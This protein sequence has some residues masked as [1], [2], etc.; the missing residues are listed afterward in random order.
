[1]TNT[2]NIVS[3]AAGG[4]GDTTMDYQP[5]LKLTGMDGAASYEC[6]VDEF[7]FILDEPPAIS[8]A[9]EITTGEYTGRV[10]HIMINDPRLVSEC[11][12]A[13]NI[14][15]IDAPFVTS[16]FALTD[17]TIVVD[18]T[19]ASKSMLYNE[20]VGLRPSVIEDAQ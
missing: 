7:R 20:V 14:R 18:V 4:N 19:G 2:T 9:L 3:R 6:K 16:A 17:R 13:L 8:A 12:S 11:L 5:E 1:M 15:P 10:L